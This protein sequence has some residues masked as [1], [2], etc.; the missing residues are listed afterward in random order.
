MAAKKRPSVDPLAR[1]SAQGFLGYVE[2][3]GAESNSY[4]VLD[5][6]VD[7]IHDSH[8]Q[9]REQRDPHR[10]HQLVHSI[11]AH[12]FQ[13][14]LVVCPHPEHEGSYQLIAGG[15]RRRDAAREAGLQTLPCLVVEYDRHRM[16]VGT[17][18]ENLV[19]E[20]LSLPDEGKLYLQLRHDAGWTQEQLAEQ[21]EV[22]RD[23]IKECEVAAR[24]AEDIQH[25]LR[26]AGDHGLRAAKAL[27]Q[28]DRFDEPARGI[29]RAAVERAPIIERFLQEELTTDGVQLAV[30]AVIARLEQQGTSVAEE[31]LRDIYPHEIRRHER[32]STLLKRFVSWQKL[33]GDQPLYPDERETLTRLAQEIQAYLVRGIDPDN[34]S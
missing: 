6:S 12:G 5:L 23:R 21:L 7:D 8:Y 11:Q 9:S 18:S 16:A 2:E 19:R 25:M 17:A 3:D 28:L 15:H 31:P 22:S 26:T 14:V 1:L 27:R 10:F 32:V 24:D 34:A 30:T 20:D 13:G 29:W 4:K 33:V